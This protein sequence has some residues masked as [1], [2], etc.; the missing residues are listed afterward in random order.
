M[1]IC[2]I[3]MGYI[4]T[5]SGAVFADNGHS[6]IGV[7]INKNKVEMLNRGK[8]PVVESGLEKVITRVRDKDTFYATTDLEYALKETEIAFI[9]V[10]TPS[11][12]NGDL[13]LAILTKV[14]HQI[15]TIVQA[16]KKTYPI[17]IRSTIKPGTVSRLCNELKDKD[18]NSYLSINVNP[19]FLREGTAISDFLNPPITVVGLS[20]DKMK[21]IVEKIYSFIDSEIVFTSI[22]VGEVIKYVNNSFHA[23]K[24]AF[25]NEISSICQKSE[26]DSNEVMRIFKMDKI[27]NV[28]EYYFNPGFAY[29]GSCLPKDL[30]GLVKF[31]SEN[32][33]T[34][35]VLQSISSSNDIQ[36]NKLKNQ[37]LTYQFSQIGF[38][39]VA[40]KN[41]TDDFRES[42]VV[43]VIE[44][45]IGKGFN[46][47]IFDPD[48]ELSFLQGGNLEFL[49]K[50]FD[51]FSE[52]FVKTSVRLF[53]DSDV[54]VVNKRLNNEEVNQLGDEIIIDLNYQKSLMDKKNYYGFNW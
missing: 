17:F 20:N 6:V 39:G 22:N 15:S 48:V 21:H 40:F 38:Y 14:I 52:L 30:R 54:I 7:D 28:S 18:D 37:L 10:G 25:T 34:V 13:D 26:I 47:K 8:S 12:S 27:L 33:I 16:N 4:G 50:H 2:I 41:D 36:I 49:K 3:G 45:L 31:S 5:V 11:K 32:D 51:H 23:L 44:Y 29:G 42:P 9:C 46:I 43:E 1:K 24:I 53:M 19:E 35:P